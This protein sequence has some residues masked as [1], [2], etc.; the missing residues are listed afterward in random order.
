MHEESLSIRRKVL[1]NEHPNV[2]QSLNNLAQLLKDQVGL[3]V[4]TLLSDNI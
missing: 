2:A 3:L 4:Q 1:G